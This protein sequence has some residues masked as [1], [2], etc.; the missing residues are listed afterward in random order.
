M[1]D[2]DHEQI[3]GIIQTLQEYKQSWDLG[4]QMGRIAAALW[5]RRRRQ[6]S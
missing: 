5:A 1:F 2:I 6:S 4:R 3:I